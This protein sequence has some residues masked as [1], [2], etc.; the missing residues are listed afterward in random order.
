MQE[1]PIIAL[2]ALLSLFITT[3]SADSIRRGLNVKDPATVEQKHDW[4]ASMPTCVEYMNSSPRSDG[5]RWREEKGQA[6]KLY[7]HPERFPVDA[8]IVEIG[9]YTGRDI[10]VFLQQA[11]NQNVPVSN[12]EFHLYEPVDMAYQTLASKY[13]EVPN[14]HLTKAGVGYKTET[15]CVSLSGDAAKTDNKNIANCAADAVPVIDAALVVNSLPKRLDLLH[16]NCEGCEIPIMRRVLE[17]S[18]DKIDRIEV[19]NHPQHITTE[20]YCGYVT[21]LYSHG[22]RPVYHYKFVWELWE[23]MAYS[24]SSRK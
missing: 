9:A 16:I 11:S 17:T 15:M 2:I 6:N 23:R 4:A 13:S 10:G 21:Q 8:T 18:I 1:H 20:D 22:F 24:T 3:T 19:Q 5:T 12:M 7:E 14:I